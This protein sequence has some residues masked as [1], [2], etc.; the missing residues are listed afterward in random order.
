MPVIS[1]I[2]GSV[3]DATQV[4]DVPVALDARGRAAVRLGIAG[5]VLAVVVLGLVGAWTIPL[6]GPVDEASHYGY[7]VEL[8]RGR[9]PT[10]DTPVPTDG[11]QRLERVMARRDSAR[12]TIWTANHPPLFYLL[13]A[14]PLGAGTATGHELGALRLGRVLVVVLAGLGVAL[15]GVLTRLLLPGRPALAVV[16]AG[17][18]ALIP[19]LVNTSSVLFNDS[20]SFLTSTAVLV[21]AV[22]WLV[23]GPSRARLAVLAAAA[24]AAAAT[25]ASGL[26][27][28]G[29]AGLAVLAGSWLH[30]A[31]AGSGERSAGRLRGLAAALGPA[32]AVGAAV[33]LTSG[34]FWLRNL[35]LYGDLTGSGV[36]L[37]RFGRTPR[38]SFVDMLAAPRYWLVHA[39]RLW[40]PSFDFPISRTSLTRWLW[41]LG[42]VP[43]AGLALATARRLGWAGWRGRVGP[44]AARVLGAA[45]RGRDPGL[46]L[47]A[48]W[49][50]GLGLLGLLEVSVAAFAAQ[51]GGAHARY[52]LPGAG[53][54]GAL[55]AVGLAAL[56]GGRRGLPASALLAAM[57]AANVWV[58]HQQLEAMIRPGDAGSALPLA[59]RAAE[60]PWPAL[61]LVL[62]GLLLVA[63]VA[64]Q[65][66][67]LWRLGEPAAQAEEPLAQPV[68][69]PTGA[70]A[71]GLPSSA[72]G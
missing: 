18:T 46:A 70:P 42:L 5:A 34:W 4:R 35:R 45:R 55:A 65:A 3:A 54:L 9:L 32:A 16:A 47:P 7:A 71:A 39:Q 1:P 72:T 61:V 53:I 11:V 41:L 23:R 22:A 38:G 6:F 8:S 28:V 30:R 44:L 60:V 56:P 2:A 13:E 25:R 24:A 19:T 52:L 59:L 57:A 62:A 36:L 15:V 64:A 10:I 21:A 50:L 29:V 58:W 40:D 14:G 26:L 27:V 33:A 17:T 43:L 20:L 68:P 37:A 12:R 63:A 48:A 31:P 67:A 69:Q 66:V 49:L 51:G